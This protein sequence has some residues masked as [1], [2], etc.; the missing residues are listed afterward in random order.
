MLETSLIFKGL[1]AKTVLPKKMMHKL[2]KNE[3]SEGPG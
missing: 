3:S 1:T 2:P